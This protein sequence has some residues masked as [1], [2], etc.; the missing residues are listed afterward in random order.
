[1]SN[2]IHKE[3]ESANAAVPHSLCLGGVETGQEAPLCLYL[4]RQGTNTGPR[5]LRQ[6]NGW[7]G[8]RH[9]LV[10][11]QQETS[12]PV[13]QNKVTCKAWVRDHRQANSGLELATQ[14]QALRREGTILHVYPVFLPPHRSMPT[15]S[16]EHTQPMCV[17]SHMLQPCTYTQTQYMH[18]PKHS[19]CA[20]LAGV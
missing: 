8:I 12:W 13:R 4:R 2:Q 5:A 11:S 20:H 9:C 14:C 10:E 6:Q 17:L 3:Q 16:P 18:Q 15:C 1:M 7:P 19:R